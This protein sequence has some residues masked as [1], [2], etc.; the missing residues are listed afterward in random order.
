MQSRKVCISIILIYVIE[1]LQFVVGDFSIYPCR[2]ND[3]SVHSGTILNTAGG[4]HIAMR[5]VTDVG[6]NGTEIKNDNMVIWGQQ[7]EFQG[8]EGFLNN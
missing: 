7:S 2:N 8:L 6:I 3:L 4:R 1:Y 5:R